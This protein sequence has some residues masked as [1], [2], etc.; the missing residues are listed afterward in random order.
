MKH[1]D[2]KEL[3]IPELHGY[4]VG[5]IGPRPVA[6]ASTIDAEGRP[7]LSPFSFFNVFG[8]NPPL[9]IFSPA[10]RGRDNTTKHSY[11]NVKAVPEVVINVV[12]Y[13]MVQQ[14]SLAS[15]EYAEGVNEFVKAGFTPIPSDVVRPF[16]VKESPVQ[17]ECRVQQ[18]IETGT[19]GGAGNLVL[20]EVVRIHVDED[21]LDER[22]KIDQRRIDLVGRMGGNFYCRAHGDALFE[23]AQ[24]STQIGVG[25][26][27]L[28]PE[29]RNSRILTG[30]DLGHLGTLLQ[31]PDETLVN[32]YKLTELSDIFI[33]LKDRPNELEESLHRR[34][35]DLL[36]A[37]HLEDA[38]K[39]LLAF[40]AR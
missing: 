32:E 12:T 30:N 1:L 34:A 2:P 35:Q 28:P 37:G 40:N 33:A 7:N 3:S 25:V 19:G 11:H 31:V 9:L 6:F 26:D 38:W 18:V 17:F 5:A 4:L 16:R 22:G 10:R 36:R 29:A 13:A 39:T 23:L 8:A 21:L 14:T 24:P 15:T 20:C 27:A